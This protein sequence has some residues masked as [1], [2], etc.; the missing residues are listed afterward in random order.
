MAHRIDCKE[1]LQHSTLIDVRSP[2]EFA[3]GHIPGAIN[4][5]LFSDE[6]RAVVGTLYT[7][8]GSQTAVLKGLEFVGTKLTKFA[9][10]AI[11][12]TNNKTVGVYCWRGG[13]RSASMAF[14]FDTTGLETYVLKGGYK[15]YRKHI[16]EHMGFPFKINILGGMTGSGKTEIL[17]ELQKLGEQILDLELLANHKGSAFGALGQRPQPSTEQFGNQIYRHLSALNPQNPIWIEDESYSIGSCYIPD[18]L[19]NAM[20]AATTYIVEVPNQYRAERLAQEYG[21]FDP[22][23]LI[24]AV[25]RIQKRLGNDVTAKAIKHITNQQINSAIELVLMYYDKSY[26]YA[27]EKRVAMKIK[28]GFSNTNPASIA[29]HL[30]TLSSQI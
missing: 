25:L 16:L 14:L 23:N 7:R 30:K 2:S 18:P 1:F 21:H 10:Q 27:L 28:T 24:D 3:Q 9:Q 26:N 11:Q 17:Y 29:S 22:Q 19:F 13:M 20:Q 4:I 8:Q 6:E 5:P 12:I 15:A